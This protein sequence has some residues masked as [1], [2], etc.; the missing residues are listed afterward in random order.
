M[1]FILKFINWNNYVPEPFINNDDENIDDEN[2]KIDGDYGDGDDK[3]NQDGKIGRNQN[4]A[5][6]SSRISARYS[7]KRDSVK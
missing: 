5:D 4:N 6:V 3:E 7:V 1:N 2:D